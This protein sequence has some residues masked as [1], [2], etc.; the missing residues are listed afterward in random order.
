VGTTPFSGP[1]LPGMPDMAEGF[2][3]ET[4]WAVFV[5]MVRVLGFLALCIPSWLRVLSIKLTAVTVKR[6]VKRLIQRATK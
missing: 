5:V 1:L 3:P 4:E 2:V 6:A